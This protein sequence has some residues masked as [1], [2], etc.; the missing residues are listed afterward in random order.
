MD[1]RTTPRPG[2]RRKA[3]LRQNI[4]PLRAPPTSHTP[5]G[6]KTGCCG[7]TTSRNRPLRAGRDAG[8]GRV[9]NSSRGDPKNTWRRQKCRISNHTLSSAIRDC[10]R[11]GKRRPIRRFFGEPGWG[12][13]RKRRACGDKEGVD[14]VRRC[15]SGLGAR[16]PLNLHDRLSNRPFRRGRTRATYCISPRSIRLLIAWLFTKNTSNPC[17]YYPKQRRQFSPQAHEFW[18]PAHACGRVLD[19][20]PVPHRV[21]MFYLPPAVPALLFGS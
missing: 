8:R 3:P 18:T 17:R 13:G 9:R 1:P 11:T 15:R 21:N 2:S 20:Q 6:V 14:A 5:V 12:R 16:W 10:P 19:P 4:S 7:T